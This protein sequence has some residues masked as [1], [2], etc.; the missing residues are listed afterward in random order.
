ML[1]II[2]IIILTISEYYQR[3]QYQSFHCREN[4]INL[5]GTTNDNWTDSHVIKQS[6]N[7]VK[8]RQKQQQQQQTT[9]EKQ[10]IKE[11]SIIYLPLGWGTREC[12]LL[13]SNEKIGEFVILL[14][15]IAQLP[16][17]SLL[18]YTEQKE[19]GYRI[20]SAVAAACKYITLNSNENYIV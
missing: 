1:V 12:C 14:K 3:N 2:L 19:R 18:P 8:I 4:T 5:C 9:D 15:G 11:L 16:Q 7:K 13:L 20:K 6:D 10:N 17:P